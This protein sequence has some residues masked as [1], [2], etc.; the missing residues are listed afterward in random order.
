MTAACALLA[1][2]GGGGGGGNAAEGKVFTYG[3]PV[4]ATAEMAVLDG[5][6][7][8]AGQ[9]QAGLDVA[10]GTGL[11]NFGSI[12]ATLLDPSGVAVPRL[13]PAAGL[14]P[15]ASLAVSPADAG[16][17]DPA[18]MTVQASEAGTTVRL[19]RCR[20]TTVDVDGTMVVTIDG[21]MTATQPGT[22]EWDL[23]VTASMTA[24]QGSMTAAAHQAGALELTASTFKGK[25]RSEVDVTV[26]SGTS[27]MAAGVDEAVDVDV[28]YQTAPVACVNGGTLE[29]KRVWTRRP[30]GATAEETRDAAARVTWTGCGTG[31]IEF[32][33]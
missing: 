23:T 6:L 9:A 16:F 8:S 25:L 17:D 22:L 4:A 21:F 28:T 14:A 33:R 24:Q 31:T 29:V 20:E 1:A 27:T 7:A 11:A 3:E 19:A 13:A 2:C 26:R 15:Q 32:S 10:S 18:C 12:S 30:P 5:L